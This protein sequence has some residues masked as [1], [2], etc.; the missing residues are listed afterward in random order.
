MEDKIKNGK[1]KKTH[2]Q[3][4]IAGM[5]I[6]GGVIIELLVAVIAKFLR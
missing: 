1:I 5:V 2:K 3:I 4:L 6:A